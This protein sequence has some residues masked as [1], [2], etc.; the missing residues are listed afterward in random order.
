MHRLN[1]LLRMI[2]GENH[3]LQE[4]ILKTVVTLFDLPVVYMVCYDSSLCIHPE[5]LI[6]IKLL[7]RYKSA[8]PLS[9]CY[10]SLQIHI[11]KKQGSLHKRSAKL[12]TSEKYLQVWFSLEVDFSSS[13]WP[14]LLLQS[15]QLLI[16]NGERCD[17]M[18]GSKSVMFIRLFF[19]FFFLTKHLI[20]WEQ[21]IWWIL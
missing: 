6:H 9:A 17:I 19:S 13:R 16:E 18:N 7:G 1:L 4:N 8:K 3:D 11:T 21:V 14:P 2:L 10:Q 5:F 20:S 15:L 12:S